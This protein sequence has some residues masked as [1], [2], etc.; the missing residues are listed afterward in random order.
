MFALPWSDLALTVWAWR[1]AAG[2]ING[3][4]FRAVA[5]GGPRDEARPGTSSTR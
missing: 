5:K 1:E 4:L 3:P 2:I